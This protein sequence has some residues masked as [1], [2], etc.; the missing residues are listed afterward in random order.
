VKLLLSFRVDSPL[1]PETDCWMTSALVKDYASLS[2]AP[3]ATSQL[4]TKLRSLFITWV[5]WICQQATFQIIR[6]AVCCNFILLM[7]LLNHGYGGDPK[8]E[9]IDFLEKASRSIEV[10]AGTLETL[11]LADTD[12]STGSLPIKSEGNA[13]YARFYKHG[14]NILL[15]TSGNTELSNVGPGSRF[16]NIADVIVFSDAQV[17][18]FLPLGSGA[19]PFANLHIRRPKDVPNLRRRIDDSFVF[20]LASAYQVNGLSVAPSVVSPDVEVSGDLQSGLSLYAKSGSKEANSNS[21]YTVKASEGKFSTYVRVESQLTG[22]GS[23]VV[24][25]RCDGLWDGL[26]AT[27]SIVV[28]KLSGTAFGEPVVNQYKITVEP[29]EESIKFPIDKFFFKR[30]ERDYT[31]SNGDELTGE[32]IE[33]VPEHIRG[34]GMRRFAIS[35]EPL[36][37]GYSYTIAAGVVFSLL[38]IFGTVWI[39]KKGMGR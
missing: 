7:L 37:R 10:L 14:E 27:P 30:Y 31:V 6:K 11:K 32:V 23:L 1:V 35:R 19:D 25:V 22:T 28:R 33:A 20:V 21:R 16:N 34:L 9:L 5:N 17:F 38:V 36:R 24:E 13:S 3:T 18:E 8:G 39:L 26:T 29:W 4:P 2:N 12:I 15:E